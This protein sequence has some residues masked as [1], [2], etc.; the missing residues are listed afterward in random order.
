[1][2]NFFK[3][4]RAR[5]IIW[6][7][8]SIAFFTL[9]FYIAVHTFNLPHSDHIYIILFT[10]FT[11]L[12]IFLIY[13]ITKS[14]TYLSSRIR[15]ISRKNLDERIL[16]IKNEDEIGELASSFN[17]LLDNLHEAFNRE[18]QFI[19][20]VAHELKTPLATLKSTLEVSLS[21]SRT[22]E[23]YRRVLKTAIEE[24][25]QLSITLNNVLDLAWAEVHENNKNTKIFNLSE[26]MEELCDISEKMSQSKHIHVICTIEKAIKIAGFREKLARALLNIIDN[27]I[28]YTNDGGKIEITLEK[29]HNR[30]F[31]T[32]KDSG[33]GIAPKDIPHIFDRFYRGEKTEKIHGSGLGLAIAKSVITLHQG[34][35]N[36][37]SKQNEG[38]TFIIILPIA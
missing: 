10:L 23:E 20:D 35:V 3:T 11:I 25:N 36:V 21:R 4:L 6:Y 28:K 8:G 32:I 17:S 26:L 34:H 1:M 18:R 38:T 31:I 27:A 9:F 24:T 12:G 7:I 19:G 33:V 5:L 14:M 22:N 15:H 30:A 16:D 2:N 13:R 37:E 29:T